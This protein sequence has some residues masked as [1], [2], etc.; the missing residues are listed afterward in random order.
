MVNLRMIVVLHDLKI[1]DLKL[2]PVFH[3]TEPRVRAHVLLCMLAYHVEWHMRRRLRP[4]LFDDEHPEVAEGER[5]SVMAPAKV[6]A[7][8]RARRW[9]SRPPTATPFTACTRC[10]TISPP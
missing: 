3:R 6:S 1:V 5:R 10:S 7:G 2:R 8:A 4:M 9:P